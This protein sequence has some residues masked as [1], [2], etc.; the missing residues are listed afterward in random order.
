MIQF[1]PFN[2]NPYPH[3]RAA[4]CS[5]LT[6]HYEGFPRA[7]IESL[8]VGTPAVSVDCQSGPA[9]IIRDGYN[10]FLVPNYKPDALAQALNN[11]IFDPE[12]LSRTTA[13]AKQSVAH[14]D[15]AEI[16]NEWDAIIKEIV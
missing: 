14:L 6:S 16:A 1:L 5:V 2:P 10:G 11:L 12:L 3:L 9:E 15:I 13:N 8:A 7:V 4:K